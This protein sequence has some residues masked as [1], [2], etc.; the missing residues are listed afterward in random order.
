MEANYYQSFK[1][2][3]LNTFVDYGGHK[4]VFRQETRLSEGERKM[5]LP[6][7]VELG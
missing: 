7:T 4:Q 3:E 1:K 6:Y 5:R 2:E